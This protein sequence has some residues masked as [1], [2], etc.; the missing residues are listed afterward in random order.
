LGSQLKT[1]PFFAE[2]SDSN[3][4]NSKTKTTE[5]EEPL[6]KDALRSFA[7]R[8]EEHLNRKNY[9]TYYFDESGD[10]Q[11]TST[12]TLF[13]YNSDK[14]WFDFHMTV[15]TDFDIGLIDQDTTSEIIFDYIKDQYLQS[16]FKDLLRGSGWTDETLID[17]ADFW[18]EIKFEPSAVL[19]REE[20]SQSDLT[21]NFDIVLESSSLNEVETIK[22]L[23]KILDINLKG[24]K[25]ISDNL[26]AVIERAAIDWRATKLRDDLES[27]GFSVRLVPSSAKADQASSSNSNDSPIDTTEL[28]LLFC[29]LEVFAFRNEKEHLT[30]TELAKQAI[31]TVGLEIENNLDLQELPKVVV[32]TSTGVS[33]VPYEDITEDQVAQSIEQGAVILVAEGLTGNDWEDRLITLSADVNARILAIGSH[34]YYE[35]KIVRQIYDCGELDTGIVEDS[36]FDLYASES[37]SQ[38]FNDLLRIRN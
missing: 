28:T 26:P 35:D 32:Y 10:Y 12:I 13:D 23:R 8:I 21:G 29:D 19:P 24:A 33:L 31:S 22:H 37:V 9:L 1:L 2:Q 18:Y 15:E 3:P 36:D 20:G 7:S 5:N 17:E 27:V 25:D 16:E 4:K 6:L 34:P 30:Q 11:T 14:F 38:M